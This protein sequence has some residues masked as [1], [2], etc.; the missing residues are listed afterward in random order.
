MVTQVAR[1]LVSSLIPKPSRTKMREE[2]GVYKCAVIALSRGVLSRGTGKI[3]YYY[4][5]EK[6]VVFFWSEKR[7]TANRYS[8]RESWRATDPQVDLTSY[9]PVVV[10]IQLSLLFIVH[11]GGI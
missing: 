11:S 8:V 4:V 9:A 7:K 10:Q 2:C 5:F 3:V 6:I 1:S